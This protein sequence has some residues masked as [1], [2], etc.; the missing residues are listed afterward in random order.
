VSPPLNT[1]L[2]KRVRAGRAVS[3]RFVARRASR[4]L[5]L[6]DVRNAELSIVLCDDAFIRA[7]NRDYRGFDRATDDLSFPQDG[8]VPRKGTAS[9]LGDVV[10]SLETAARQARARRRPLSGEA[11]DL[12]VHGILHLVGYD[13]VTQEK[14]RE[15][16]ARAGRL[17]K[18]LLSEIALDHREQLI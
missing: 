15:M 16:S 3:S 12:L 4:I 5:D 14:A 18:R 9:I 10:I 6:L 1:V 8:G 2:V 17:K 11:I 13:H 7:L